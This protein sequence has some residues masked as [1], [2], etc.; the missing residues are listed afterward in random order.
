[1]PASGLLISCATIAATCPVARASRLHASR[2]ASSRAI[3]CARMVAIMYAKSAL[4]E[5]DAGLH[6]PYAASTPNG[7]RSGD[8]DGDREGGRAR[9]EQRCSSPAA[10]SVGRMVASAAARL[11]RVRRERDR[12]TDERPVAATQH[13]RRTPPTGPDLEQRQHSRSSAWPSSRRPRRRAAAAPSR[14]VHAGRSGPRTPIARRLLELR[15]EAAPHRRA[16]LVRSARTSVSSGSTASDG[17]DPGARLVGCSH[18]AR[19]GRPH[20]ACSRATSSSCECTRACGT[21]T[22]RG[23]GPC[24]R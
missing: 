1:M 23:C 10:P 11:E 7:A 13:G 14:R 3:A 5:N 19:S 16:R 24:G 20:A 22:S 17:S 9:R 4:A 21:S 12:L 6:A 15:F 8:R 18:A 2:S